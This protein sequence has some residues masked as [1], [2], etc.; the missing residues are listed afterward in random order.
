MT[1]EFEKRI[2]DAQTE[3]KLRTDPYVRARDKVTR[4]LIDSTLIQSYQ[5]FRRERQPYP[6]VAHSTLRPG[7]I[8][9]THEYE[10]H[11]N[12]LVVMLD[13]VLDERLQKHFR[14]RSGNRLNKRNITSVAPT[15]PGLESYDHDRRFV[16]HHGFGELFRMLTELD[17]ALLIQRPVEEGEPPESGE[18]QITHFHVK[19]ERLLDSALHNLGVMLHY[20]DRSLYEKGEEYVELF[21]R[22]FFEYFNFYH[23]AAGRRSAAAL[24]AQLLARE[25]RTATVF[26]ASQQ[27]RR[28]TLLSSW[29]PRMELEIEQFLLVKLEPERLL[30][31]KAWSKENGVELRRHFIINPASPEPVFLF[32]VRYQHTPAATPTPDG[33]LR[34]TLNPRERWVKIIE[35]CFVPVNEGCCIRIE[36]SLAYPSRP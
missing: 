23:N 29:H 13:G 7:A 3:V 11:Y 30:A 21:E 9:P 26:I 8:T 27:D 5:R 35:E 2:L 24:A 6:F 22:K 19:I 16:R 17:Y 10:L 28:L 1:W 20:I 34:T 36:H 18:F 32:R 15:L 12:A 25:T 14:C 4:Q 33:T 31:L